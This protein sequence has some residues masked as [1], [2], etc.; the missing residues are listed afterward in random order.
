VNKWQL[1]GPLALALI[2][3][4]FFVSVQGLDHHR[5]YIRTQTRMIGTELIATTNSTRLVH[6]GTDLRQQLVT[7]LSS[8]V[9]FD[10]VLLGDE[11]A[12]I[13]NG[14]A[15]C[16]LILTNAVGARLGMRLRPADALEKFEVLGFWS[17]RD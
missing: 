11:P 15:E 2:G 10:D 8:P 4:L 13:G 5:Y 6:I 16:R 9:G 12:P 1:I 17:V 14:S 3:G 7:L